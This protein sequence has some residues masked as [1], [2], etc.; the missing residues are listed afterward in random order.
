M[1]PF[2]KT[3]SSFCVLLSSVVFLNFAAAQQAEPLP[4][5]VSRIQQ[6]VRV[7]KES[8]GTVE[9]G[10]ILNPQQEEQGY[11]LVASRDGKVGWISKSNTV[12]LGDS[13]AIFSE[14]IRRNP[15]N[16]EAYVFRAT[17][18]WAAGEGE[19]AI[20]DYTRAI[21]VGHDRWTVYEGRGM[22][23]AMMGQYD[24]AIADYD[25]ALRRGA[26]GTS[27]YANRAA[28]YVGLERFDLAIKDFT[29]VIRQ[30]PKKASAYHQ[31]AITYKNHGEL[32]KAIADFDKA[33]S[34]D[35]KNVPALNGRGFVY[36][37]KG[38]HK[39][40]V[41]EFSQVIKLN[42]ESS[43]VYNNRGYNYQM[44][45]E[46]KKALEDFNQAIKLAP[47]YAWAFQ[48]KA[49]LLAGA[50]DAKIRN[51]AAALKAAKTACELRDYKDFSDLKALAAAHA[52]ASNF[53]EAVNWQQK[54]VNLAADDQKPFERELLEK[55]KAKEPFRLASLPRK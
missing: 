15:R 19:K 11:Y 20:A 51:G 8:V 46:Y 7:G 43:L 13:A 55:Y 35:P 26:K 53:A 17:A 34:L 37:L 47:R 12:P 39:K 10:E 27:I 22:F 48:N 3:L 42:G 33:I 25:Q 50:D 21:Q 54:A 6:H 41:D 49:W 2:K 24:K 1:P 36:Y 45:G 18:Y 9:T 40:A 52:E 32:D 31:R 14:M 28:A 23:Y 38:E 29:E 44:L 30:D 4:T 5:V 16:G